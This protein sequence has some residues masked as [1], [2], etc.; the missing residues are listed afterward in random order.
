MLFLLGHI[1][2]RRLVGDRDRSLRP[3]PMLLLL[4]LLWLL[5]LLLHLLLPWGA[6]LFLRIPD[7]E[8]PESS[9]AW[10]SPAGSTATTL[11]GLW[12]I[13]GGGHFE[14]GSQNRMLSIITFPDNSEK[15]KGHCVHWW[16]PHGV[17][18]MQNT[19]TSNRM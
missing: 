11:V 13:S 15:E 14:E 7:S 6:M 3:G 1:R 2:G 19:Y 18:L 9:A 8:S 4:L 5:V 16:K 17:I 10:R 12:R